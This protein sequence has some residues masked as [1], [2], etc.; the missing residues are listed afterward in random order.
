MIV[1][2]PPLMISTPA[3]LPF[4][5]QVATLGFGLGA[6]LTVIVNCMVE[7]GF[8]FLDGVLAMR[9]IIGVGERRS[10]KP[11]KRCHHNDCC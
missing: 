8:R 2:V 5:I 3:T 9:A 11:R 10:D 6:A 4:G 7:V 1:P